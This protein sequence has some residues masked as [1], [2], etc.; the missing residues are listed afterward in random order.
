MR[1]A[2][3]RLTANALA[4]AAVLVACVPTNLPPAISAP[5]PRA[6][7]AGLTHGEQMQPS[8]L[9]PRDGMRDFTLHCN[10]DRVDGVVLDGK[11]APRIDRD[12]PHRFE[13]WLVDPREGTIGRNLSLVMDDVED[14]A[15]TWT[16]RRVVRKANPGAR[17]SRGYGVS[18]LESSFVF[19]VDI[20]ELPNGTYHVYVLMDHGTTGAVCD[21]GR[22]VRVSG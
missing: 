10:L 14:D 13:G 4:C 8:A 5:Q 18:M 6:T 11:R 22:L 15:T 12:E 21:P 17:Q 19:D 16:A 3:V 2:W 9:R 20:A 1:M 7:D